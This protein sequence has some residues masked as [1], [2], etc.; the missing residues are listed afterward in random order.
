MLRKTGRRGLHP[1][2]YPALTAAALVVAVLCV[3]AGSVDISPRD[4]FLSIWN[5]VFGIPVADENLRA[6]VVFVRLPRVLAV[7]LVG[8]GLS[9][10]GAA[11]Q[12]LL[13]NPLADG[14]TLGVSSGAS[15]G[16]VLAIAL[17]VTLPDFPL[18]GTT[19]FAMVFAFL[20]LLLILFIAFR[21]DRSLSTNTI[22]LVGVVFSMF[23]SSAISLI[24]TA[25]GEK[26]KTI[27]FWT[28]GSLAGSDYAD[29]L[30]L[31]IALVV[32]GTALRSCAAELNALALGE[33]HAR[34]IGVDVRRV[35]LTVMIAASAL[36][37]VCVSAGGTIAFMG[38][39]VPHMTRAL[40]GPDHRVSMPVSMYFGAVFLMLCD[41][42]SRVIVSPKQLP[43]GVVT[44]FIG[45]VLFLY[46]FGKGRRAA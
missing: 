46:I 4:T 8:A 35:K 29:V 24:V 7:G 27:T 6:I 15:L 33:D 2:A 34:N 30:A 37:G 22:I 23:A 21:I 3:C 19:V 39:V 17:G 42:V 12:G 41:L 13:I 31:L 32:C 20:S 25:V 16:A 28:M 14:S 1:A 18:G 11:M 40:T 9:L 38:L 43:V 10:C 44:S 26:A 45:A 36:I 5:T